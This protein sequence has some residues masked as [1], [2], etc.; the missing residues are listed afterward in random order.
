MVP[1]PSG[2]LYVTDGYRNSRVHR[3]A[4]N[5]QLIS[6]WGD[7]GKGGPNQFHLP[8]SLLIGPDGNVYV[9]DREN[10][11]IQVFSQSGEFITMWTDMQR[12]NDISLDSEGY[13]YT[14]ERFSDTNGP[15]V[16]VYDGQGTVLARW[17]TRGAHGMWVDSKGDIYLGLTGDKSVDKYVRQR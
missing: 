10:S 13:F 16:S 12:P 11:R 7:P 8:H 5:G 2:E 1:A 15:Q 6:S 9:C 3:F 14:C 4:A 17:S